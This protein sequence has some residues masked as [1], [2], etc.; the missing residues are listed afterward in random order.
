MVGETSTQ[1]RPQKILVIGSSQTFTGVHCTSAE[2]HTLPNLADFDTLVINSDP[3]LSAM[4]ERRLSQDRDRR[5]FLDHYTRRTSEK[6]L[7][8]LKS[9]G[10][11]F[12]ILRPKE[13]VEKKERPYLIKI[14]NTAWLPLDVSVD[15]KEGD[16]IDLVEPSLTR[17][18]EKLRNWQY[19]Y[20][21]LDYTE[22]EPGWLVQQTPVAVNRAKEAIA[23][24]ISVFTP[25]SVTAPRAIAASIKKGHLVLLPPP[26]EGTIDEA[27]RVI[28]ED[29]C[30]IPARATAPE[31]ITYVSMPG[32]ERID[33]DIR[34]KE[35]AIEG[36]Q[37]ELTPLLT[38][39]RRR[40]QFKAILYETGI[41][42]LQDVVKAVFEELG[43][44]TK[45]SKVSDEFMIEHE[46]H[47]FLVE[48]KGND[49]S[50][51][52]TDLRQ[53]IDY[54]LEHEQ[55]LGSPIK[56]AL[57]VNAWRSLPLERRGQKGTIVFPDNVVKRARDNSIALLDTVELYNA[58]NN[59]WLG[60]T[61]GKKI[62][63]T[64]FDNRGIVTFSS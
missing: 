17:Y 52:L 46:G 25:A 54:Q 48:V 61:D 57:I 55:K 47:E 60:V 27:I 40:E 5:N 6:L 44:T 34:A 3:F 43:L 22:I 29:F 64:I 58:L 9:G 7:E 1:E 20:K 11:V 37:T 2:L 31:W 56:S 63:E 26:T 62:F 33:E 42:P 18:F 41:E 39:R 8:L 21:R 14:D 35:K 50:A 51:K 15:D 28:L 13:Y 23:V 49:K 19:V 32:A 45:P 59:F 38:E 36:I 16:T 53:L 12:V 4:K 10:T 24:I 30:G